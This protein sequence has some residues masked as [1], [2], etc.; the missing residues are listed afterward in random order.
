MSVE[1]RARIAEAT[2]KRWAALKAQKA[3]AEKANKESRAEPGCKETT[4]TGGATNNG[5]D[6]ALC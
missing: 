5:N 1:G 3:E 4:S 6:W 2:R